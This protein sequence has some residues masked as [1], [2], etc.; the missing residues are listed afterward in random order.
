VLPD[1]QVESPSRDEVR[2]QPG[3]V[4]HA[5]CWEWRVGVIDDRHGRFAGVRIDI[6][7]ISRDLRRPA[8]RA[9]ISSPS[10]SAARGRAGGRPRRPS[11]RACGPSAS[12]ER[13]RQAM[14][15]RL[16]ESAHARRAGVN[17]DLEGLATFPEV[18]E[19]GTPDER[20]ELVRC[21]SRGYESRPGPDMPCCSGTECRVKLVE[22]RGFEPL[23]PR[24]PALCSP[25]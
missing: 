15:Q 11:C 2:R 6:E 20:K 17:V 24:L 18:L 5:A 13:A 23:T 12:L 3:T 25:N 1:E 22:L 19:A 16:V 7:S 9:P 10:A 14:E 21:F 4:Y 8:A